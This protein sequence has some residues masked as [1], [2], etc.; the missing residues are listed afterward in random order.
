MTDN[1][2]MEA[3]RAEME[4]LYESKLE[5]IAV[6]HRR[7]MAEKEEELKRAKYRLE[8]ARQLMIEFKE[9]K[10]ELERYKR[11]RREEAGKGDEVDRRLVDALRIEY[12]AKYRRL[13][14]ELFVQFQKETEEVVQKVG[15]EMEEILRNR[16]VTRER[17]EALE[18]EVRQEIRM[19]AE[20][21]EQRSQLDNVIA[22]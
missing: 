7:A 4:E 13:E 8:E 20:R 15:V 21:Q 3:I 6:E 1:R 10:V 19:R 17:R 14:E 18:E 16:G 2:L 12:E 22:S 9:E 5:E 11:E